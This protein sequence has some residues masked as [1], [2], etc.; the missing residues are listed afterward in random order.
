MKKLIIL[1]ALLMSTAAYACDLDRYVDKVDGVLVTLDDGSVWQV[2]PADKA[3]VALWDDE[4]AS[5][6]MVV[7]ANELINTYLGDAVK[8]RRI[9]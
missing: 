5:V 4:R 6:E 7:C 2:A 8:A 1:A 3:T 9:R